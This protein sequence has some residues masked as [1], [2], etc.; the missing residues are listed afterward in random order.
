MIKIDY[1]IRSN[2]RSVS[3]TISPRCEVV[4]KAPKCVSLAEIEKIVMSKSGWITAHIEKTRANIALNQDIMNY[5]DV[6]FLGQ[7]YHI[8][9]DEKQKVIELEPS[10][11]VVPA[12]FESV[13]VRRLVSWYKVRAYEI[14]G[15]RLEYF[16]ALM[17]LEPSAFKLTNAKTCWGTCNS[18]GV[19]SLNWRL[20][21]MPHD[22]VDYVVVH[23]LS[24]L[25]QMNHS[26]LFWKLVESVLPDW[27][28][29]RNNLKKGD[30]LLALFRN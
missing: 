2:R 8:V 29:R 22:I 16:S 30:Y 15:R 12:K 20:I 10:Y 21:M 28:Q 25:V 5:V 14:L 19:V 23:E 3:I 7:V 26:K 9:Y 6:L 11:C 1:L 24:H 27:K 4:V 13:L 17:K 18:K